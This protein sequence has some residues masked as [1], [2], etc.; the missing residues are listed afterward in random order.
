VIAMGLDILAIAIGI[1]MFA[2]LIYIVE[3]VDLI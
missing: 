1:A 2:I 3:G